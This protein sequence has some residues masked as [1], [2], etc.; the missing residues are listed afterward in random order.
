MYLP[1]YPAKDS[2]PEKQQTFSKSLNQ[3]SNLKSGYRGPFDLEDTFKRDDG[4]NDSSGLDEHEDSSLND[5]I[6]R[7]ESLDDVDF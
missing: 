7:Q 6:E 4:M 5:R 1:D 3:K 2:I